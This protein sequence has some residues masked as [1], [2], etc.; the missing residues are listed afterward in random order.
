MSEGVYVRIPLPDC[1][2][3]D[4]MNL[5]DDPS[6]WEDTMPAVLLHYRMTLPDYWSLTVHQHRLLV[7]YL[8][9]RGLHGK[10]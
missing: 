2:L 7:D 9:A 1:L 4:A 3:S 8:V 5:V 6:Y 10:P